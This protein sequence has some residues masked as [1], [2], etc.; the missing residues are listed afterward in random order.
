MRLSFKCL[1]SEL[2]LVRLV[3]MTLIVRRARLYTR[4]VTFLYNAANGAF[5]IATILTATD[6]EPV[7]HWNV[8]IM[9]AEQITYMLR[10]KAFE[11][12]WT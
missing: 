11:T 7:A 3:I 4:S 8:V 1:F 12:T 9:H 6:D 10:E 5:Y 2:G